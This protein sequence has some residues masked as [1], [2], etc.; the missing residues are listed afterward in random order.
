MD[1]IQET[2]DHFHEK[3]VVPHSVRCTSSLHIPITPSSPSVKIFSNKNDNRVRRA[4]LRAALLSR[5][6][7]L[8][9]GFEK[10][11][12]HCGS[13]YQ[14]C[15]ATSLCSRYPSQGIGLF[16]LHPPRLMGHLPFLLQ[17]ERSRSRCEASV[18]GRFWRCPERSWGSGQVN[19]FL[20]CAAGSPA[21]RPY[22]VSVNH[23]ALAFTSPLRNAVNP[24]LRPCLYLHWWKRVFPLSTTCF[25]CL[26]KHFGCDQKSSKE[27]FAGGWNGS[28]TPRTM[29]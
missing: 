4:P 19:Q 10:P 23:P 12:V 28:K 6:P 1:Y 22:C 29:L 5:S 25:L 2:V 24:A 14:M 9:R 8:S 21:V 27:T 7:T 13:I 11:C 3:N 17:T 18:Q 15:T 16:G 26:H 20:R